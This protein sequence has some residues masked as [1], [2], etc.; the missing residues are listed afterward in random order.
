MGDIRRTP[1]QS[2]EPHVP[3]WIHPVDMH[4]LPEGGRVTG[5][6]IMDGARRT[7]VILADDDQELPPIPYLEA[8][9][10]AS[11]VTVRRIMRRAYLD[12]RN[13]MIGD[14]RLILWHEYEGIFSDSRFYLP[15]PPLAPVLSVNADADGGESKKNA[16]GER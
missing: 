11:P 14:E 3:V 9:L 10:E 12:R 16:N 15:L 8:L 13:L 6:L 5:C 7:F 1:I 4:L 2:V